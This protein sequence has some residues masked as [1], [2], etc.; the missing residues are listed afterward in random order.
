LAPDHPLFVCFSFTLVGAR[1]FVGARQRP[2]L[3]VGGRQPFHLRSRGNQRRGH[4][5]RN[6]PRL[7][8]RRPA[9]EIGASVHGQ[10]T[11][12]APHPLNPACVRASSGPR[13]QTQCIDASPMRRRCLWNHPVHTKRIETDRAVRRCI[14]CTPSYYRF[15]AVADAK[16]RSFLGMVTHHHGRGS[17]GDARPLL[18]RTRFAPRA[19]FIHPDK[20]ASR[21]LVEKLGFCHEGLLRYN[22]RVGDYELTRRQA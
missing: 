22:L 16:T 20:T 7:D 12:T 10:A 1:H 14:D 4:P 8:E 3:V 11:P 19:G 6:D 17:L 15:W 21:K 2:L 18:W 9:Y 13:M 5:A